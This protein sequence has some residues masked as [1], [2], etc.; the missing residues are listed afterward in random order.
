MRRDML[1]FFSIFFLSLCIFSVTTPALA[2]PISRRADTASTDLA[3]LF[4][5]SIPTSIA[6]AGTGAPALDGW[7]EN[8]RQSF[9]YAES[10]TVPV[11]VVLIFGLRPSEVLRRML[12]RDTAVR[13]S[14]T[15]FLR[16]RD[17]ALSLSTLLQGSLKNIGSFGA[18]A[19]WWNGVY[20]KLYAARITHLGSP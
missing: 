16:E 12:G 10:S 4:Q 13:S 18:G 17:P 7:M 9:G 20:D 11:A 14:G 8:Y 6:S 15:S 2:V 5:S 3:G 19:P 1:C